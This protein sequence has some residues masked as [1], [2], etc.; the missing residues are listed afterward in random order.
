[1]PEW[2]ANKIY[3]LTLYK[4][5]GYLVVNQ[6][7]AGVFGYRD[8]GEYKGV[9]YDKARLYEVY[10]PVKSPKLR[11]KRRKLG[12]YDLKLKTTFNDIGI[13]PE[14]IPLVIQILDTIYGEMTGKTALPKQATGAKE[15][16]RE[17][18]LTPQELAR[19]FGV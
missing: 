17:K 18:K 7:Q 3:P 12:P 1:M 15:E 13:Q 8:I 9:Q 16:T 11:F 10:K 4:H 14:L 19:R 2:K 6:K 5:R